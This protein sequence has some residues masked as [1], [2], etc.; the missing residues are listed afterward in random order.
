MKI[1]EIQLSVHENTLTISGER[2]EQEE[3]GEG[4]SYR[5]EKYF[6]RF[7]RSIT[8]PQTV[9]SNK[10]QATYRDGVLTI[11]LPCSARR[12]F[13]TAGAWISVRDT[14]VKKALLISIIIAVWGAGCGGPRDGTGD[15]EPV[16]KGICLGGTDMHHGGEQG[17]LLLRSAGLLGSNSQN[18]APAPQPSSPP[19]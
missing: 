8:L 3:Q 13:S 17:E 19:R 9:D 2:N 5:S 14:H 7:Q 18:L 15:N 10:I 11:K 1:E 16:V 6:G 4:E 12:P